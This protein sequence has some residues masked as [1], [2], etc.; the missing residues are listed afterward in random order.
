MDF[1]RLLEQLH[2]HG[3]ALARSAEYTTL[4][5]AV[6]SCPGW[7]VGRVLGHLSKVQRWAAH[8]VNSG[9]PDGFSYQRP[10]DE[11]LLTSFLGGL[12]ELIVALRR[13]PED[14]PCWTM[15]PARSPR[16]FWARRQAHE[17]AIHRVDVELA[18]GYGVSEFE[19]DF[20]ADGV[21]ELVMGM[22]PDR[23]RSGGEPMAITLE[24]LDVN[25][26]WT[27]RL[28]PVGVDVRREAAGG[29]DLTVFGLASEL[30]RWVWNRA[31]DDEVSLRGELTTADRWHAEVRVDAG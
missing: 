31:G 16:L 14:R 23:L 27:I 26:S 22:V 8:I 7:S 18:A 6:P 29:A 20:A 21:D 2:E 4:G 24:P 5:A 11:Q 9:S 1:D 19:P 13:A 28:A 25:V 10:P 3:L 15:W 30:Y 17:T 12:D